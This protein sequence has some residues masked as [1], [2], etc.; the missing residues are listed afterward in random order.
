MTAKEY[1][2]RVRYL[3]ICLKQKEELL[4]D[5]LKSRTH[6]SSFDYSKDRVQTSS[7]GSGFTNISDEI[8][9]LGKSIERDRFKFYQERSKIVDQIQGVEKADYCN[10]LY[11]RYVKYEPFEI[12]AC[13]MFLSYTRIIHM[14]GEALNVFYKKYL[15][16]NKNDI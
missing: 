11:R 9:D 7:D 5:M 1:L 16:N 14:H 6:L 12:I 10:L 8:I 15:Q 3:D 13:N 4:A 2:L